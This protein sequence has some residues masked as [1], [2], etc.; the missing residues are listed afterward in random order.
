MSQSK[1]TTQRKGRFN[2]TDPFLQQCATMWIRAGNFNITSCGVSQRRPWFLSLSFSHT[3]THTHKSFHKEEYNLPTEHAPS[4]SHYVAMWTSP[5]VHSAK[6]CPH[7]SSS[8]SLSHTH[9]HI[10]THFS[11][12]DTRSHNSPCLIKHFR[13]SLWTALLP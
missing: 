13:F 10:H 12:F 3:D 7:S 8:L 2:L 4:C 6:G 11:H 5:S 1:L 9:T